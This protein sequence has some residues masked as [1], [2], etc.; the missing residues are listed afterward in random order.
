MM[1]KEVETGDMQRMKDGS[2][3]N[4]EQENPVISGSQQLDGA[5]AATH[6]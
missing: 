3:V 4:C 2:N 5:R 6:M 1:Q